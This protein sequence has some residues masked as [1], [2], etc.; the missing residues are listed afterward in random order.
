MGFSCSGFLNRL[1][2]T[3]DFSSVIS[4]R[5]LSHVA[6]LTA[7]TFKLTGLADGTGTFASRRRSRYQLRL[8][9]QGL[10]LHS[11]EKESELAA[12]RRCTYTGRPLGTAEFIGALEKK[13]LRRLKLLKGGRPGKP[14]TDSRQSQLTFGA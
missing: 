10:S 1:L 11:R 8:S 5:T 6:S 13:M 2:R 4:G 14:T 12:I 3:A 7:Y 9:L